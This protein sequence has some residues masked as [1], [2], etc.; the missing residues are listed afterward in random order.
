MVLPHGTVLL[1]FRG[2]PGHGNGERIGL[3]VALGYGQPLVPLAEPLI[4][5]FNE[6]PFVFRDRRGHFHALLHGSYCECGTHY[7][8]ADGLRWAKSA[9]NAYDNRVEWE[10]GGS[11]VLVR[12]DRPQL[13]FAADGRPTHVL[14]GA[15]DQGRPSGESY[16]LLQRLGP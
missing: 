12:R 8:S 3:A 10:G 13:H 16:T 14:T 7:F 2:T 11:T 6:D 15:V 9:G 5:D 4:S 1:Y